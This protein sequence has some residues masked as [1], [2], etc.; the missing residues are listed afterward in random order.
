MSAKA[1]SLTA[2]YDSVISNWLNNLLN[3]KFPEKKTIHGKLIENLRYG[4]N[5]HQ[6]GSLYGTTDNL[7][8]EKLH[9]KDLSYNNYND[10]YSALSILESLKKNEGIVIIKHTNPC[11]VSTEKDQMKSFKNALI[12]DPV[13]AFG[14]VVAINSTISRKLALEFGFKSH[15][16]LKE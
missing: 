12:C 2:Y 16:R 10:I 4:E 6:Q 9:G 14:G 3:I 11:G 7:G 8:L 13:S 15:L 1:F 5:P